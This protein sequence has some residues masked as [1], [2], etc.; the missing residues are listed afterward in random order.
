[1]FQKID[2]SLHAFTRKCEV[3]NSQLSW[4]LGLVPQSYAGLWVADQH[5]PPPFFPL[6]QSAERYGEYK[7]HVFSMSGTANC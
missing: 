1:M 6:L 3:V 7:K 5:L 2:P 4:Q